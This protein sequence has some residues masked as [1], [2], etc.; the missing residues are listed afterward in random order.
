[1]TKPIQQADLQELQ[2]HSA[3]AAGL[4]KQLGNQNRLM[5]LCIT[6]ALRQLP[7]TVRLVALS[8]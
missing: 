4:L 8:G 2:K 1:M 7:L 3:E 6:S 5:I